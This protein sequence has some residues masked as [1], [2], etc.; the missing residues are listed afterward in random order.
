MHE[1]AHLPGLLGQPPT[2]PSGLNGTFEMAIDLPTSVHA[3]RKFERMVLAGARVVYAPRNELCG[4]RS[5]MIAGPEG[6]LVEIGSWN[7]G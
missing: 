4:M 6:N 2:Y 5:A 3:D 1:C 7:R